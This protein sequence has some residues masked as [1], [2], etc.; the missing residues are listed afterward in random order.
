MA[1]YFCEKLKLK[2]EA[3][4]MAYIC[5]ITG[6]ICPMVKYSVDGEASPSVLFQ[7]KGCGLNKKEDVQLVEEIKIEK[8]EE[9]IEEPIS[10]VEVIEKEIKKEVDSE[11]KSNTP[12]QNSCKKKK[13]NYNNQNKNQEQQ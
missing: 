4:K 5:T 12:R 9:K 11:Q 10:V 7:K 3:L 8:V 1:Q 6:K 13:R 2:K